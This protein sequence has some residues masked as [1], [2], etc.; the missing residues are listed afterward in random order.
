MWNNVPFSFT[1]CPC[2]KSSAINTS[3]VLLLAYNAS[4]VL[5]LAHNTSA[6][7]LLAYNTGTVLLLAANGWCYD[8]MGC[9]SCLKMP[10]LHV[11]NAVSLNWPQI[12]TLSRESICRVVTSCLCKDIMR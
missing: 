1:R 3:T 11:P 12:I 6:V 10:S 5:L 9:R 8:T 4:T 2:T 7:L